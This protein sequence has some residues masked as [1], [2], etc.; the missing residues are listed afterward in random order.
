M[1]VKQD[2]ANREAPALKGKGAKHKNVASK[3]GSTA[4]AKKPKLATKGKTSALQL[5]LNEAWLEK[6]GEGIQI[7]QALLEICW[8]PHF[9]TV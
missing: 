7:Y 4:K 3:G 8:I 6:G 9:Q 1:Q 5:L 2:R